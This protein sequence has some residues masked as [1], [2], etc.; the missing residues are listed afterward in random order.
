[1]ATKGCEELYKI[2]RETL[3]EEISEEIGKWL[4]R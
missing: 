3:G 2:Q 1:L 4:G